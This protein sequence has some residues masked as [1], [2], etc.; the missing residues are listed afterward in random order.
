MKD[1]KPKPRQSAKLPVRE[2]AKPLEQPPA[3]PLSPDHPIHALINPAK[4][5]QDEPTPR[6]PPTPRTDATHPISPER[7]FTKVPNSVSRDVVPAGHFVG[8]SKQLYDCLFQ[9]TRGAI[10][11]VRRLAISKPDLMDASAIGSERTLLKNLAHLK[12]IGLVRVTYTDGRHEGNTYE[13][14]TPEEAGLRAPRTPP[15]PPTAG[16]PRHA[17]AEVPPVPPAESG[18]RDVGSEPLESSISDPPKTSFKT[19]EQKLDDEAA[20]GPV[21]ENGTAEFAAFAGLFEVLSTATLEITGKSPGPVDR[22]RWRELA[23]LLVTELRIAAGRTTVSSVPA[24]LAEH[25]RR[26][27]WK[28]DK[29]QLDAE[30]ASEGTLEPAAAI[31]GDI[32]ECPSCFGTGLEYPDGYDKGVRR[33]RHE[34]LPKNTSTEGDGGA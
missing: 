12:A 29:R 22:D 3:R 5:A 24:F 18:V 33:C 8:K 14:F 32:S 34:R 23:D 21:F 20:P 15:T 10:V 26:R 11:P 25:L 7:D 9:R 4:A 6:T 16:T 2:S 31:T 17:R 27:L 13:V 28:T 30:R 19:E 1:T